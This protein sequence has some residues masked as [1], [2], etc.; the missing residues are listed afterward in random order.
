MHN[1]HIGG[2]DDDKKKNNN[3]QPEPI[4]EAGEYDLGDDIGERLGK[5]DSSDNA[6]L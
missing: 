1:F 5:D 6:M 3:G 2:G 4:L